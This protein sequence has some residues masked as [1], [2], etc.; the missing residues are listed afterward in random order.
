MSFRS[1]SRCDPATKYLLPTYLDSSS[2]GL[3]YGKVAVTA[4]RVLRV[5]LG[6]R[7]RWLFGRRIDDRFGVGGDGRELFRLRWLC[8]SG[9]RFR[10]HVVFTVGRIGGAESS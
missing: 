9:F 2:L 4:S 5:K 3:T 7:R 10:C 8:C 1:R 6:S